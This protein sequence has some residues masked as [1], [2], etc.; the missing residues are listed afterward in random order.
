MALAFRSSYAAFA[1]SAADMG[2]SVAAP[3]VAGCCSVETRKRVG[4]RKRECS[5]NKAVDVILFVGFAGC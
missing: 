4:V 5:Q 1:A 3:I 2:A